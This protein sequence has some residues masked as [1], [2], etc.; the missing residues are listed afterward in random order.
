MKKFVVAGLMSSLAMVTGCAVDGVTESSEGSAAQE[1]AAPVASAGKDSRRHCTAQ[2]GAEPIEKGKGAVIAEGSV[3]CFDT[4]AEAISSATKGA[5]KLDASVTP[6]TIDLEAAS[7]E[8]GF[9]TYLISIQYVAPRWD[10]FWGSLTVSTSAS[11]ATH[12]ISYSTMPWG[13][14]NVISSSRTYPDCQHS[15]HYDYA[16]FGGAVLD[17]FL[18]DNCY[19]N[20]GALDDRTSSLRWTR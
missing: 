3:Q 16:N 10:P 7:K 9:A 17:C 19:Y 15:Y 1:A 8:T 18:G 12:N 11:C 2:A 20:L 14:D 4:F 5:V 13:W 6:E